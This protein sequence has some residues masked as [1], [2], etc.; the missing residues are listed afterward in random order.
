MLGEYLES[1]FGRQNVC[2]EAVPEANIPYVFTKYRYESFRIYGQQYVFLYWVNWTNM[3]EYTYRIPILEK[4]FSLPI[5]L[6]L[7]RSYAAQIKNL[8][9]LK[10]RFVELGK[11]V[12]MPMEGFSLKKARKSVEQT[13]VQLFTPQSQLCALFFLYSALGNYT[14][15]DITKRTGLNEM[16]VSRGLKDL[17]ILNAISAVEKGNG[18]GKVY[19]ITESKQIFY[20]RI[21]EHL[22]SPVRKEVMIRKDNLSPKC[23]EAGYTAMSEWTMLADDYESTY[24]VLSRDFKDLEPM[25][26]KASEYLLYD[27][28]YVILQVWKYDPAMFSD[29]D[30][31]ADK[32]SVWLSMLMS[33]P[34]ERTEGAV[35]ELKKEV[36]NA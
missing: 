7:E 18:K 21:E 23:Y 28:S 33:H 12:F 20:D 35:N 4:R 36:F 8:R 22:I 11:Q 19:R 17:V 32:V 10:I 30:G 1:V 26:E 15:K 27:S 34:D 31:C 3:R 2:E 9:D 6:V 25:C 29:T 13:E 5:V 14:V 24:A 16:A